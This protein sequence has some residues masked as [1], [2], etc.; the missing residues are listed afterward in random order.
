MILSPEELASL[1]EIQHRSPH[2]LLGLHS[3]GDGNG[4][5]ARAFWPGAAK[6]EIVPTH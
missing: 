4:L 1:T 2:Q 5:V 3:L 6:I